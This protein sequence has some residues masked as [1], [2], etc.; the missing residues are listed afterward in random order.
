[1]QESTKKVTTTLVKHA[2]EVP[3]H[4]VAIATA[5]DMQLLVGGDSAPNFIMRRFIMGEGGG[6]PAHHNA[7]E[8]EQYV[9]HG[10][11]RITIDDVVYE[12]GPHDV[13]SI[14]AGAVHA[15]EAVETPFVF[16]CVIPNTPDEI[17]LEGR[18]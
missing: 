17:T 10:T 1:M 13:L 18:R 6:M 11:G 5:C 8:H 4:K 3:R 9:L 14:P 12:V 2:D 15:Y 16:L 7:V